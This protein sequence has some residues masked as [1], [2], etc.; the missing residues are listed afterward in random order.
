MIPL[1]DSFSVGQ[2]VILPIAYDCIIFDTFAA[3]MLDRRY[4]KGSNKLINSF[5][6]GIEEDVEHEKVKFIRV[7]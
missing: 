6:L 2:R 7:K 4:P 1:I 3:G 5:S